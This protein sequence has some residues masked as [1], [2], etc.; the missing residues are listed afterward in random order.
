[1]SIILE[2]FLS[3]TN[4]HLYITSYIRFSFCSF[5]FCMLLYTATDETSE[6]KRHFATIKTNTILENNIDNVTIH[7]IYY[8]SIQCLFV[9]LSNR[10][11][12]SLILEVIKLYYFMAFN[13]RTCYGWRLEGGRKKNNET[14][15]E[16]VIGFRSRIILVCFSCSCVLWLRF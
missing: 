4:V 11:P 1:M 5:A 9:V 10:R 8:F 16:T 2:A 3:Y 12:E 13:C 14:N 15:L 7:F 6:K